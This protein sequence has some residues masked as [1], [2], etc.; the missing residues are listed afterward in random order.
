[1]NMEDTIISNP[2]IFELDLESI[3]S[4]NA[5]LHNNLFEVI[6]HPDNYD[7]VME[8]CRY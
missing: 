8:N 1:M 5:E 7:Y 4:K 2:N 3:K 6:Y